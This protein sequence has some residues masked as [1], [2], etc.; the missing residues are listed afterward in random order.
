MAPAAG[1]DVRVH[2]AVVGAVALTIGLPVTRSLL[3]ASADAAPEGPAFAWP[4]RPLWALG[5]L[6]FCCLLA[7]GAAA[8]WSAVYVDDSL[9][10][11]ASQAALAFAA[12]SATMT[13]G[14]LVGDRLTSAIGPV[15]L[16]RACGLVAGAG[17]GAALIV[18]VPGAAVAGVAHRGGRR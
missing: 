12:F 5:L 8:D 14:R 18:A 3:P 1:V 17:L 9:D 2:L 16:L 13:L 4:S 10:A 7:E 15:R 6:A 11:P